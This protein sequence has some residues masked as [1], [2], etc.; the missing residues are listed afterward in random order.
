MSE[1]TRTRVRNFCAMAC[2]LFLDEVIQLNS[3]IPKSFTSDYIC[4]AW[5]TASLLQNS[6]EPSRESTVQNISSF[7]LTIRSTVSAAKTW[8]VASFKNFPHAQWCSIILG[9]SEL[10]RTLL[11]RILSSSSPNLLSY[12][13]Q[14]N[15]GKL[16]RPLFPPF[17]IGKTALNT[18]FTLR[19]S[20]MCSP[21]TLLCWQTLPW[22]YS[23]P[24]SVWKKC[25]A[26]NGS[27]CSQFIQEMA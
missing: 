5:F 18:T 20:L 7:N 16:K 19:M 17:V 15:S 27:L 25:V 21:T 8:L 3:C 9:G 14:R 12:V 11:R 24:R 22:W 1:H 2:N 26:A 13:Q 10:R 4:V 6:T 23:P